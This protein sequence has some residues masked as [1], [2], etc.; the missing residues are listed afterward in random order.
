MTININCSQ[1]NDKILPHDY[2][3]KSENRKV[4]FYSNHL[5]IDKKL[6]LTIIMDSAS[7]NQQWFIYL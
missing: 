6:I 4:T 5:Q 7:L 3:W 1:T 2:Y